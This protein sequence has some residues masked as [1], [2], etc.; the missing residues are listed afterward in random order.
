MDVFLSELPPGVKELLNPMLPDG[1]KVT[2]AVTVDEGVPKL[3]GDICAARYEMIL[4]RRDYETAGEVIDLFLLERSQ[5]RAAAGRPALVEFTKHETGDTVHYEY[6]C[7]MP[8][9]RSITPD[10]MI[11]PSRGELPGPPRMARRALYVERDGKLL[12]PISEGV[13]HKSS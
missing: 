3:S 11:S 2:A 8:S 7:T 9:G 10:D 6:V 5:S 13:V 1:L 4:P 12:C